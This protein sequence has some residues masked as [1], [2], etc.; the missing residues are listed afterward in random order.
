MPPARHRG[1]VSPAPG[2]L[3]ALGPLVQVWFSPHRL[4]Q[5]L[6]A[7]AGTDWEAFP[8]KMMVDTGAE[9]TLVED[10]VPG[11]LGLTPIRFQ[12][13]EG[14]GGRVDAPVY[15]LQIAIK[16]ADNA[17]HSGWMTFSSDVVAVPSPPTPTEQRP[18]VGLLGR[19]FLQHIRLIYDG[20]SATF[21]LVDM[22][23]PRL[24]PAPGPRPT[25]PDKRKAKRKAQKAARRRNRR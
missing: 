3:V 18:H 22:N 7:A 13:V 1:Q 15:R 23:A 12:E 24:G 11:T 8:A 17:G 25:T 19:D 6:L 10:V 21:E 9:L 16:A 2:G 20:P 5:E 4:D 14:I